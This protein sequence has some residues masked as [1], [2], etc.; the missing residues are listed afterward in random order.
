MKAEFGRHSYSRQ[1]IE[2]RFRRPVDFARIAFSCA[3]DQRIWES[4]IES[5]YRNNCA[6]RL[7]S[8]LRLLGLSEEKTSRKMTEWNEKNLIKYRRQSLRALS[9]QRINIRSHTDIAATI[10]C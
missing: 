2:Y 6:I 9:D 4:H 10:K 8:A 7:G 1:S 3:G 5:G